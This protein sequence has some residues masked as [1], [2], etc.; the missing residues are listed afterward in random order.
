MVASSSGKL[1]RT[2]MTGSATSGA[3]RDDEAA[4]TSGA[5]R[6]ALILGGMARNCF[7]LVFCEA[8]LKAVKVPGIHLEPETY[9]YG[10]YTCISV[11]M[12]IYMEDMNRSTL[13]YIHIYACMYIYMCIYMYL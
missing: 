3:C 11:Y 13:V 9:V 12:Y 5:F 7:Q 6:L 4:S 8:S 1:A 10:R 2:G